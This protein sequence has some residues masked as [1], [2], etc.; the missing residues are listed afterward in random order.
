MFCLTSFCPSFR[1][2]AIKKTSP[3][4]T[5]AP[6]TAA[7]P[8]LPTPAEDGKGKKLRLTAKELDVLK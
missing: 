2:E 1:A 7:Q 8:H 3:S 5:N 4:K 6:S